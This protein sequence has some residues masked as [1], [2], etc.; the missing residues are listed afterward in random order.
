LVRGRLFREIVFDARDKAAVMRGQAL[1]RV[2]GP[3][4]RWVY[5]LYWRQDAAPF[6]HALDTVDR[7]AYCI[8]LPASARSWTGRA[9]LTVAPG[10]LLVGMGNKRLRIDTKTLRVTKTGRP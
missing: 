9:K 6:V 2:S 10:R 4:G 1:T 7:H 8:D 3:T 5:T